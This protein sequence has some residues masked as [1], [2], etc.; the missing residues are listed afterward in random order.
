MLVCLQPAW[1]CALCC[2]PAKRILSLSAALRCACP[3][4]GVT[5]P[6]VTAGRAGGGE[7]V[8]WPL[9]GQAGRPDSCVLQAP[10]AFC[11]Q[12]RDSCG[13]CMRIRT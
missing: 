8:T 5:A 3:S 1:L 7:Q 11:R 12:R 2:D 4:H 6:P 10:L 13:L 9:L